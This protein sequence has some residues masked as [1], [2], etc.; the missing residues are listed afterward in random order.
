[1]SPDTSELDNQNGTRAA[2]YVR[3]STDYQKYSTTNQIA[4]I[5]AYAAQHHLTI[6]RTY[7]DDGR[8]GLRIDRRHGLQNLIGDVVTGRADFDRILV[9]DVSRWGRFQ[10]A[11]E[12]AHYEFICKQA[13]VRV[14]YCSEEFRNDGSLMSAVIKNLKRVMAGE[15]SRELSNKV[16]AGQ[17][18]LVKLGFRQGGPPGYGLR[19]QLIDENG[20]PKGPLLPG[21]RKHLQSDRVLILPGPGHELE[22]VREVFRQCVVERKTDTQ[23][24]RELNQEGVKNR[25][26]HR[27]TSQAIRY[28]LRNE[29]YI[30]TLLYNRKTCRLRAPMRNNSPSA[31]IRVPGAFP[32]IVDPD[33]FW[34]AQ[35]VKKQR[36]TY[37][38]NREILT[39]LSALLREKGRLSAHIIDQAEDLPHHTT[40]IARFGSLRNTYKLIEYNPKQK[41]H[42]VDSNVATNAAVAML[43]DGI[44]AKIEGAGGSAHF[45]RASRILEINRT[46]TVSIYV[47]QCLRAEAGWLRWLV[48]RRINLHG[49]WIASIKLLASMIERF[50][51]LESFTTYFI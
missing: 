5:A 22:L 11:D 12:S 28:L 29:N 8:S 36:R 51:P 44:I 48:R 19:R 46:L 45:D 39:R 42:P 50:F 41:F 24:A 27:W 49:D 43:A 14:E 31:W 17:C 13:G 38:S 35:T 18:R 1:M 21:Q 2:Q 23:I 15:Y 47:A 40:C 30:G 37:L 6:V 25:L 10:D 9:Y 26:A 20:N 32:P 33:L 3:M 16:F 4:A 34:R 7:E